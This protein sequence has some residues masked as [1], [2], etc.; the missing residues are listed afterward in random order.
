MDSGKVLVCRAG[1]RPGRLLHDI[2][3]IHCT[4]VGSLDASP[5]RRYTLALG[6]N[7]M[8]LLVAS[9]LFGEFEICTCTTL[10]SCTILHRSE[11]RS[12]PAGPQLSSVEMA[13][14][15]HGAETQK[16]SSRRY[17]Y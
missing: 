5:A 14:S 6:W 3:F 8:G 13:A 15:P 2:I 9:P 11:I 16:L 1:P 17:R 10:D 7:A 4:A 12:S